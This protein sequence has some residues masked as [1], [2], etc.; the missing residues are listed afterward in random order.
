[1]NLAEKIKII[2]IEFEHYRQYMD[3]QNLEFKNREDGF[4]VVVGENGAGKSNLLNLIYWCF[5]K[6]EPHGKKNKGYYIINNEYLKNL[7]NGQT[8]TMS[9]KIKIQK[10]S[11]QYQ[12]SRI[13]KCVKN[14]YQYEKSESGSGRKLKTT[15]THGYLLPEGCEVL[16]NQSTFAILKKQKSDHDFHKV[17]DVTP[18]TLMNEILPETLSA[19]FILDGEYLEKFW[20]EIKKVETGVEQISQ[21]HLVSKSAKHVNELK[22]GVPQVGRREIDLLTISIREN[23]Y[24]EDSKDSNGNEAWSSE[25]RW[26]Y[27]ENKTEDEYYHAT[28][29]PRMS[30]LKEDIT[31]MDKELFKISEEFGESNIQ[32]VQS[33]NNEAKIKRKEFEDL[34]KEEEKLKN[35]YVSSLIQNGPVFFLKSAIKKTIEIVDDLRI[36]GDLPYEAKMIFTNDLL[37]RGLCICHASLEEKIVGGKETNAER[38]NVVR[39]RDNMSEDKGLDISVNMKFHYQTKMLADFDAFL[40]NSFD[41]PRKNYADIKYKTK[42]RGAELHDLNIKLQNIGHHD[43]EKLAKDQAYLLTKIKESERFIK[44][45]EHAIKDKSKQVAKD[46]IER[47]KLL[48]KDRRTQK[49]AYEQEIWERISNIFNKAFSSLK[50]EIREGVEAKTF[51]VFEAIMYK[52]DAHQ[53]FVINEDYSTELFDLDDVS[54]L[55]SLSAGESLFLALSFISALRDIT[56]YKFPLIIDTPLSRVSGTPRNLLGNALPKYLPKEQ[57]IFLATDT[58]FLNPDTNVHEIAGRPE[59]PFGQLLEENINVN[60]YLIKLKTKNTAEINPYIPKWRKK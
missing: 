12:I 32:M 17:R 55:E 3:Y 53:R 28:G 6:K 48:T 59:I 26:G 9:V 47:N 42:T 56:G 30:E 20:G 25:P 7:E 37:E 36:K 44:D 43:V 49:L 54:M 58:E 29:K 45:E 21:L 13:L 23:E 50:K 51:E 24:Y 39:I 10:G 57:L 2:S 18:I 35:E 46:K 1:M 40:A 19:Y 11:D 41:L 52:K 4:T 22:K 34:G 38:L 15:T 8:A 14:E 31:K 5:Y 33:L 60:Y 16:E 27:D